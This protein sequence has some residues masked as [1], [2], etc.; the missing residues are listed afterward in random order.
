MSVI[1]SDRCCNS[2]NEKD[3]RGK[4]L[5][6]IPSVMKRIFPNFSDNA[7]ICAEYRKIKYY[8]MEEDTHISS[9]LD[10]TFDNQIHNSEQNISE[11]FGVSLLSSSVIKSNN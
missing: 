9:S 3:H 10:I 2:Y 5:Q 6:R 8:R 7:K 11:F 1:H 4:D